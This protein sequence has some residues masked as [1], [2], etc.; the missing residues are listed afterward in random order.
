MKPAVGSAGGQDPSV[1]PG[2]M[3]VAARGRGSGRRAGGSGAGATARGAVEEALALAR[4]APAGAPGP[5]LLRA[6]AQLDS[7]GAALLLKDLA[8]GGDHGSAADLFNSWRAAPDGDALHALCDVSGA[9]R[10]PRM[11]GA[12]LGGW[13]GT[14]DRGGAAQAA[15]RAA[16]QAPLLHADTIN[17]CP[18]CAAASWRARPGGGDFGC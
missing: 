14:A 18:A 13:G 1:V 6:C 9:R 7:R 11:G 12:E 4:G 3:A 2:A 16:R 17:A 10:G 5:A 8:K 15:G